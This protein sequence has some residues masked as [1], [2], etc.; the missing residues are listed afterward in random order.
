MINIIVK[1]ADPSVIIPQ[2]ATKGSAGVDIRAY[3]KENIII[4]PNETQ[5]I[6]TGLF[7]EIPKGYEGQIRSRSGLSL[8]H[9]IIVLN[10]P[11]TIDS[12]YRGEIQL[13]LHNFGEHNFIVENNARLAQMIICECVQVN[14]V[15]QNKLSETY[16]H[17]NGFGSTGIK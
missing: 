15:L 4:K 6:P 5:L 17:N 3:C 16:R 13:I 14:F 2:Y 10:S 11:G 8:N 1:T 7:L 12:D 9:G